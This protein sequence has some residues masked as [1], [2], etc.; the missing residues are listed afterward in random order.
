MNQSIHSTRPDCSAVPSVILFPKRTMLYV[1][2]N[3]NE[4]FVYLGEPCPE[5]AEITLTD[6]TGAY[7]P[8][9]KHEVPLHN[10]NKHFRVVG[11]YDRKSQ[12]LI[13][14]H[15]RHVYAV[16]IPTGVKEIVCSGKE[17]YIA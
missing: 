15:K 13:I 4:I 14:R 11:S 8:D 12:R 9:Q 2:Y 1:G 6:I 10:R 16:N 3:G 17:K 5:G 7:E